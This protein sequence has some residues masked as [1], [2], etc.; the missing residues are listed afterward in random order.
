MCSASERAC[1]NCGTG[2]KCS[3]SEGVEE[4][5]GLGAGRVCGSGLR[6]P[7]IT[8]VLWDRAAQVL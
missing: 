5:Q 4:F 8:A 2:A 7:I 3:E 1:G 6:G